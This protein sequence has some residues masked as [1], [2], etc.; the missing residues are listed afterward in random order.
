MIADV[1]FDEGN[2]RRLPRR[3]FLGDEPPIHRQGRGIH[4]SAG[5]LIGYQE[6]DEEIATAGAEATAPSTAAG[7]LKV[8]HRRESRPADATTAPVPAATAD[9]KADDGQRRPAASSTNWSPP[10]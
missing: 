1:T 8:D 6:R 2:G 5:A 9:G 4:Q 7:V 10:T 3:P